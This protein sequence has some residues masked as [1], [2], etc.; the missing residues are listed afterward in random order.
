ML[1]SV[2]PSTLLHLATMLH[3]IS[4]LALLGRVAALGTKCSGA[5]GGGSASSSGNR[6]SDPYWMQ[7]IQRQGTSAFNP[8]SSYSVYRN[9]KDPPY[10]AKGD[11]VTDD[12][13][14]INRAISDGNRCG[15]TTC[16]SSTLTPALVFFPS[17]TYVVS[18][19]IIPYYYTSLV[20]DGNNRPTL[21]ASANF[22]GI[23][24]IDADVY[25]PG[26]NSAEWYVPVNNFFRSVRNFV[27]DTT[28]VPAD[29][30]GTGLHWQVGQA[31][32]LINVHVEMSQASGNKHQGIFMENGSGG[33]MAQLSF[34]GGAFGMWISNQQ[35]TIHDVTIT[36]AATAI[37]QLWDCTSNSNCGVGFD[38]NTGGLTLATQTASSVTILDSSIS[39]TPIGVRTDTTQTNALGGSIFLQNVKFDGSVSKGLVDSSGNVILGGNQVV[40]QFVQGNVYSGTGT[41]PTYTQKIRTGPSI[42]SG[43]I[44]SSTGDIYF[45]TRPQYQTF[46]TS[47]FT[48]VKSNGAKGDGKTDDTQAIQNILNEYWGCSIIYFDAGTYLVSDTIVIPTG[49]YVVG[50]FWSTILA[51]GSKFSDASNPKAVIQV[52]NPGDKGQVEISDMVISTTAGSAGAIGI[53]WSESNVDGDQ[54]AVGMWDVHVRIGGAIG[55]GIQIGNCPAG[56][57]AP[58]SCQGAFL[59]F[60]VAA[61]G[62]GYFENVWVWAADHDLDDPGQ[63]KINAYSARGIFIDGANSPVWLVG[64]AAEHHTFYQYSVVSS[65]NVYMGMIQTETPYYQPT[66]LPPTP[67]QVNSDWDDPDF[68]ESGSAWGLVIGKSSSV[69]IYG[70]GLYSFFVSYTQ[71][72]QNTFTCQASI[73]TVDTDSSAVFIYNLNTIG[74]TYMMTVGGAHTAKQGDNTNGFPSTLTVWSSTN[75]SPPPPTQSNPAPISCPSVYVCPFLV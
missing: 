30:Y 56:S 26:G 31:T 46:A 52:G 14:A 11:G 43:L 61:T 33:F 73:A 42:P 4:F 39:G 19:P 20:G 28:S 54:G 40:D 44:D 6:S 18:T 29:V 58:T 64:T 8:D 59:G 45:R 9:V 35:F 47:Q 50:E 72:C 71:D 7:T 34:N 51:S 13:A 3:T 16:Q 70:A 66:P 24:V 12:T 49:S 22:N 75:T 5:I 27:I 37:Y 63:G 68:S 60:H 62:G 65:S 74:T 32:S 15:N 1:A 38:L 21:K 10:N 57:S 17:G 55:T 41:T 23:A 53:E 67:F 36:N 48:S 69:F 25:I 2:R